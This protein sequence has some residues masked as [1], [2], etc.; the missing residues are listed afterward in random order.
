MK[1]CRPFR[2]F[3]PIVKACV[4]M[5]PASLTVLLHQWLMPI[6]PDTKEILSYYYHR[7][8]RSWHNIFNFTVI[9]PFKEELVY[10]WP[11]LA[12]LLG[13][14]FPIKWKRKALVAYYGKRKTRLLARAA[15]CVA[16]TA[17]IAMTAYWASFHDYPITVFF[18]GLV[19]GWLIFYTKNPL[20]SW[21][22]HSACNTA[23]IALIVAG[24]HLLY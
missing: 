10:R 22:F 21:L 15:Y 14:L 1:L 24:H 19:W 7:E 2:E 8:L 6:A 4:L 11:A 18:Y 5:L 17:M 9:I 3:H 12:L 16:A 13:L 23:A 20:Y